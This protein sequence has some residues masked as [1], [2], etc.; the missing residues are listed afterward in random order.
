MKVIYIKVICLSVIIMALGACVT[1]RTPKEEFIVDMNKPKI[2]LGEV[3][4]QFDRLFSLGSLRKVKVPVSYFPQDDAVC[5]QYRSELITYYQFWSKKGR[6]GFIN[7]LTQYYE[8]YN[9]KRLS[10][11]GRKTLK[12]YGVVEGYLVWQLHRFAIKAKAN[13]NVELGYQFRDKSP[14]LTVNQREAEYIESFEN[15]NNRT[16]NVITLFF[17]RAQ[18]QEL[19]ALFDPQFLLNIVAA[20]PPSSKSSDDYVEKEGY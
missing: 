20:S 16:S 2:E 17:T 15:S 3:E 9:E 7:T 12:H 19:A 11:S 1:T 14:Y 6:E 8:D 5:L 13:M 4:I 10:K 18:A